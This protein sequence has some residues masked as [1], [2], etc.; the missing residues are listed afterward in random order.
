MDWVSLLIMG[1]GALMAAVLF[2]LLEEGD[3]D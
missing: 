2:A 1:A 3:D